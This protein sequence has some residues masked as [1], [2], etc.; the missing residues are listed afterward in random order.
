M[1]PTAAPTATRRRPHLRWTDATGPHAATLDGRAVAGSAPG[2]EILVADPAVSRLH[3]EL[4]ARDDGVWARDLGSR[5]GTFVEG[6]L[7]QSARVPDGGRVQVG[8]T[9]FTVSYEP[10][11]T[12]VD[13]WPG[14][15]FGPLVGRSVAMRELFARLARLAP[16]DAAV[17][18]FGEPGTGKRLV[19]EA[20]HAASSRASGPFVV[21]EC[22]ALSEERLEAD[23]FGQPDSAHAGALDAAAGGTLLLDA[24]SELPL[25][26]Q[27]RLLRALDARALDLRL[28]AAAHRDLRAMVNAGAFREDLYARLAVAPITL[29]PLRE[30]VEDIPLLAQHFLP[31]GADGAL[32]PERVREL[33]SRP[34]PGNLRELRAFVA[35]FAPAPAPLRDDAPALDLDAPF[36]A[37]RARCVDRFERAYLTGLL[38]RHG[39]DLDAVARG[40][41]LDRAHVRRLMRKHDL[42][43]A[44]IDD[45]PAAALLR[46]P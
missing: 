10:T 13:L 32:T 30:R 44:T 22:G 15:R 6:V 42:D 9:A 3:V 18:L 43:G 34:W 29:S 26:L 37:Q 46:E 16:T 27:A 31:R 4:E 40:A 45:G 38:A 21:V 24:V 25:A 35:R 19:A 7:V 1:L 36:E 23:L 33:L 2:A 5:N 17:L 39:G 12:P 41:G 14:E 20:L 8:S 28:V 11:P